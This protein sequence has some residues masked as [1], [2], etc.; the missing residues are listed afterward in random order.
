MHT[1]RTLERLAKEG[2]NKAVES[3]LGDRDMTIAVAKH[4]ENTRKFDNPGEHI[5][6]KEAMQ[7]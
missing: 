2:Q 1:N 7:K 4:I 5:S 6:F 3:P